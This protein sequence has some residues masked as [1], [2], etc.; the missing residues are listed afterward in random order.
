MKKKSYND[1]I[2]TQNNINV[3]YSEIQIYFSSFIAITIQIAMYTNI[4]I[5][6]TVMTLT[7]GEFI[8]VLPLVNLKTNMFKMTK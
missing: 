6:N 7:S 8:R 2:K 3:S 1:Q 4:V 5:I